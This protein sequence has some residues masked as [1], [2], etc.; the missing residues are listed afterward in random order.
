MATELSKKK[1][2]VHGRLIGSAPPE[3]AMLLVNWAPN[4][5]GYISLLSFESLLELHVSGWEVIG[6]WD[7]VFKRYEKHGSVLNSC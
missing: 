7:V 6:R 2:M 5:Y 4:N 1:K 3:S